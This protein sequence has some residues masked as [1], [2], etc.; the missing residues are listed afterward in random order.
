MLSQGLL[1]NLLHVLFVV[2]LLYYAGVCLK[3]K[4]KCVDS[5]GDVL[6]GLAVGI[7]LYHGYKLL[8]N[9]NYLSTGSYDR[10]SK[11]N[12]LNMLSNVEGFV[13]FSYPY[14]HESERYYSYH[15]DKHTRN[16]NC[17]HN[18]GHQGCH[19]TSECGHKHYGAGSGGGYTN[20]S[21]ST[22]VSASASA[23]ASVMKDGKELFDTVNPADESYIKSKL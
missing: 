18:N 7:F 10:F 12:Y 2:P 20:A 22:S 4:R 17:V 16:C 11:E 19:H 9:L 8:V 5:F 13:P 23:S 3:Y 15:D 14:Q 1:I 21:A 6:L